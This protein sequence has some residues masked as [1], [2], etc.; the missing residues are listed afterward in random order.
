MKHLF[1]FCLIAAVLHSGCVQAQEI[2]MK[3]GGK[4][5]IKNPRRQGDMI[6][7]SVV[8]PGAAGSAEVG[9]KLADVEKVEMPSPPGLASARSLLFTGKTA[10]AAKA[11][12]P[13]FD[14]LSPLRGFPGSNWE[15]VA[16]LYAAT[17][18]AGDRIP[19]AIAILDQFEAIAPEGSSARQIAKVRLAGLKTPQNSQ[20]V[21]SIADQIIAAKPGAG[22]EAEANTAAGDAFLA[23]KKFDEAMTRY[24]RVVIFCPG[25]RWLGARSLLGA[26]KSMA[27]LDEKKN[28]VRTL[29]EITSS[30]PGT[31]QAEAAAKMMADGGNDYAVFAAELDEDETAAK[32][33]LTEASA[34]QPQK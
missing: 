28:C 20:A 8:G 15:E 25:D 18:Q 10:E 4:F 21:V 12:K 1:L 33:R 16:L 17:L 31:P 14:E 9:Y 2:F 24:L 7:L 34:A 19:E 6:F 11:I 32:K 3:N 27:A 26:A 29:R 23:N 5:T 13:A 30:F 22:V